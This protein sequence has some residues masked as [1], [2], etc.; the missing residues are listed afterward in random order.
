VSAS[1]SAGDAEDLAFV[2]QLHYY[3]K[4]YDRVTPKA[5]KPLRRTRR[6]FRTI[7]ASRDPIL[8]CVQ[9]KAGP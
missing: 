9:P 5:D 6:Q 4:A 8:Q 3:D 1:H 2:G 7:T